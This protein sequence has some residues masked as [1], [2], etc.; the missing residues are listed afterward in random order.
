M[1]KIC[2]ARPWA[3]LACLIIAYLVA[4]GHVSSSHQ[5]GPVLHEVITFSI[6]GHCGRETC[7]RCSESEMCVES[8]VL[9]FSNPLDPS[10]VG[11]Q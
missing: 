2:K 4:V 1:R 9:S 10:V 6:L 11:L 7:R 3:K 5:L 8:H